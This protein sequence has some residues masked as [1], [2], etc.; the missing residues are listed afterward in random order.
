MENSTK[1]VYILAGIAVFAAAFF[2]WQNVSKIA[3]NYPAA[4]EKTE[5]SISDQKASSQPKAED[6]QKSV[7]QAVPSSGPQ[8]YGDNAGRFS[9]KCPG[10]WE[11]ASNKDYGESADFFECAKIFSGQYGFEDGIAVNL[12]F[13]PKEIYET[14]E[15]KGKKEA[16]SKLES[17]KAQDNAQAYS[18]NLFNGWISMKSGQHTLSLVAFREAEN[19]YYEVRVEAAGSIRTDSYFKGLADSIIASFE[20]KI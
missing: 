15:V 2:A 19:G 12:G 13:V 6:V 3:P 9:F 1:F 14:Y 18:N 5:A 10:D 8:T 16:E 7:G 17:I 4:K 11:S 20:E